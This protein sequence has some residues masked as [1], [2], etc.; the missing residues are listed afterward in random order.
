M[1]AAL[2]GGPEA[3]MDKETVD[4]IAIKKALTDNERLQFETQFAH[5]RKNPTTALVLGLFLGTLGID[6]FYNGQPI[7]GVLKLLTFGGLGFWAIIDWFLIM[8]AVRRRNVGKAIEIRESLT[9][10]RPSGERLLGE[11]ALT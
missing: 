4:L 5:T 7:L 2:L 8:G 1:F 11:A 9:L 10:L 3:R 6:R